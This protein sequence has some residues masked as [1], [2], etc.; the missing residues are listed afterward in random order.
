MMS[1]WTTGV[2]LSDLAASHLKQSGVTAFS[3]LPRNHSGSHSTTSAPNLR[4][5]GDKSANNATEIHFDEFDALFNDE[6]DF[7]AEFSCLDNSINFATSSQVEAKASSF[8]CVICGEF[9]AG[10]KSMVGV[11]SDQTIFQYDAQIL[12]HEK[13]VKTESHRPTLFHKPKPVS[14]LKF[15]FSTLS[16]DDIITA[17][18]KAAL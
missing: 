5:Q 1:A 10:K 15:D 13:S 7:G 9:D 17:K 3:F 2:N 4:G 11:L 12:L 6:D 14:I 8:G 16:P 18:Q